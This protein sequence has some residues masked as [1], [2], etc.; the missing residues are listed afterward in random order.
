MKLD[1]DPPTE[2]DVTK[3]LTANE[4]KSL[5]L[6]PRPPQPPTVRDI[7]RQYLKDHG[8]EGLCNPD[9]ECGCGLADLIPCCDVCTT[10]LPARRTVNEYGEEIYV[11]DDQPGPICDCI[12]APSRTIGMDHG[13]GSY[14]DRVGAIGNGQVPAVAA[15]AWEILNDVMDDATNTPFVSRKKVPTM[16]RLDTD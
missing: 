11:L 16:C 7:V 10:C 3:N 1:K 5:G 8:H 15:L 9:A 13:V 12:Q 2:L 14:V 4:R 6:Q